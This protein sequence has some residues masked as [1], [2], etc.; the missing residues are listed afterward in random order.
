MLQ[1]RSSHNAQHSAV[2]T[3]KA[4]AHVCTVTQYMYKYEK[5][6]TVNISIHL[7]LFIQKYT[8]KICNKNNCRIHIIDASLFNNNLGGRRGILSTNENSL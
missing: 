2:K 5:Q 8:Q 3:L 1:R 6:L 4:E 7:K